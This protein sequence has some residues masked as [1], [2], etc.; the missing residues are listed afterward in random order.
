MSDIADLKIEMV[1][2]EKGRQDKR[3]ARAENIARGHLSLPLCDNPMLHPDAARARIRPSRNIAGGEY[4]FS[5]RLQVFVNQNA[6]VSGDAGAFRQLGVWS[7]A[8]ADDHE[9]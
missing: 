6:I 9:I 7:D 4:S 8:D 3:L 5:A 1:S 2:P